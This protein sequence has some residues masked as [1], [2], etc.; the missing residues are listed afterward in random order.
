MREHGWIWNFSDFMDFNCSIKIRSFLSFHLKKMVVKQ[1]CCVQ[2]S[3]LLISGASDGWRHGRWWQQWGQWSRRPW[4]TG[5]GSFCAPWAELPHHGMVLHLHLLH[6]PHP[7]GTSPPGQLGR[8]TLPPKY[9][10]ASCQQVQMYHSSSPL[11]FVL[12]NPRPSGPR[13]PMVE[14]DLQIC[15]G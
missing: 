5:T 4:G 15:G 2:L 13:G 9:L 3:C 11:P 12:N 6:L 14:T 7:R 10:C 8:Q 1:F